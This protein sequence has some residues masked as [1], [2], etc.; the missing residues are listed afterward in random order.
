MKAIK[1]ILIITVTILFIFSCQ[2]KGNDFEGESG[3]RKIYMPQAVVLDGGLTGNYPVPNT[4]AAINYTFDTTAKIL[5]IYLGA[6]SS[7]LQNKGFSVTVSENRD[8]AYKMI[9]AGIIQKAEVLPEGTYTLPKSVATPDGRNLAPFTLDV[10]INKLNEQ[11]PLFF[12]RFLVLGVGITGEEVDPK[13]ATTIVIIDAMQFMKTPPPN[14]VI[15]GGD[16][17]DGDISFWTIIK[18]RPMAWDAV[19]V[20]NP[21]V[22]QVA[23]GVMSYV[24]NV[25]TSYVNSA[26]YQKV[27]VVAGKRYQVSMDFEISGYLSESWFRIYIGK[28]VPSPTATTSYADNPFWVIDTW[29]NGP[30]MKTPM[31]ANITTLTCTATGGSPGSSGKATNW[32]FTPNETGDLYFLIMAGSTTVGKG[33]IANLKIDNI[34]MVELWD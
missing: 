22:I 9:S 5:K 19:S 4:N 1:T 3:I 14:N 33:Q 27:Q 18:Q 23:N 30:C 8:T 15:K 34:K 7:G 21:P 12:K 10:D 24:N 16:M 28:A 31:I 25:K 20:A 6:I 17:N 29:A 2:K 13:L 32:I 11:Y 26:I